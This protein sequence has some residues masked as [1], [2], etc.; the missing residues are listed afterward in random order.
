MHHSTEKGTQMSN[1]SHT[2]GPPLHRFG[3]AG[4]ARARS[5]QG[6]G[7][8][9]RISR[10]LAFL[11]ATA[12]GS[13]AFAAA[14]GM[15]ETI[16]VFSTSFAGVGE[17]AGEL[18]SPDGV[19]VNSTTHN[20]YVADTGN[21]RIDEFEPE[22]DGKYAFVRAWGFG[23]REGIVKKEELQTCTLTCFK[24]LEGSKPGEFTSPEFVAVDNSGGP[25]KGDVYVGDRDDNI[26]TKFSESGVLDRILGHKGS[27]RRLDD[28]R[29]LVWLL[30]LRRRR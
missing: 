14:P 25:S 26:V 23:V 11:L 13:L 19:A 18:S 20:I 6:S 7:A 5:V 29:W 15:A 9:L 22:S 12:L 17:G 27:A 3:V 8:P 16:H 28:D 4:P 30:N 21:E 1:Q 2:I 10:A 24:G